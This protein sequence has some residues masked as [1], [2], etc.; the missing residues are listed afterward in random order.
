MTGDAADAP[1]ASGTGTGEINMWV[2]RFSAPELLVPCPAV[3]EGK[4]QIAVED[5]SSG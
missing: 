5:V 4:I 3:E 2:I 1:A